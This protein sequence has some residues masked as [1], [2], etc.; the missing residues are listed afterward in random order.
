MMQGNH[1]P[2]FKSSVLPRTKH[3][4]SYRNQSGEES[5]CEEDDYE[6]YDDQMM[7]MEKDYEDQFAEEYDDEENPIIAMG[8]PISALTQMKNYARDLN[9]LPNAGIKHKGHNQMLFKSQQPA[10][11]IKE[12]GLGAALAQ[13]QY[14]ENLK[15]TKITSKS[16]AET[17]IK[18][19]K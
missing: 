18:K 6:D 14:L 19:S 8:N 15:K 1:Q 4:N 13:K 12:E 3:L 11:T 17:K 10:M 9:Y 5:Y 16:K 2:L 7:L